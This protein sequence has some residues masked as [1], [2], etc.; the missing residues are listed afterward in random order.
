M[1]RS[2]LVGRDSRTSRRWLLGTLVVAASVVAGFELYF[3]RGLGGVVFIPGPLALAMLLPAAVQAYR[4]DGLLVCWALGA[5]AGVGWEL[6]W[7][8][9]GIT[10]RPLAGRLVDALSDPVYPLVGVAL[11]TVGFVGGVGLGRLGLAGTPADS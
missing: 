5:S 11:A 3:Q 4:N 9:F 1:D 6:W 2:L 7:F 10:H 8:G